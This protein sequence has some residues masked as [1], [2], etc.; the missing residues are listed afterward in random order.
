ME[1]G[2]SL[3]MGIVSHRAASSV[4]NMGSRVAY[5]SGVESQQFPL[6]APSI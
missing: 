3:L 1:R 5:V 6:R 4:D 2:I